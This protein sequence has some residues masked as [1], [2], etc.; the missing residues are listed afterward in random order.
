MSKRLLVVVDMQNDFIDG[1]LANPAAQAIVNPICQKIN[2]WNGDIIV[3]LDTHKEDYLST[4]EGKYM[5]VPHCINGTEGHKLNKCIEAALVDA[6]NNGI[7]TRIVMKPTF[8]STVLPELIRNKKYDYI[9]LVGTCTSICVVSNA[10]VLKAEYPETNI[11]V[12]AA[13]CACLDDKHQ[14]AA[15]TVMQAC[16]I[17]ILNW[18]D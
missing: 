14:N 8:G 11:A 9:E 3:T 2:G 7:G 15:L 6:Q 13:C 12:D 4:R 17:D 18:T 1:A 16:Q 10:M 5:P